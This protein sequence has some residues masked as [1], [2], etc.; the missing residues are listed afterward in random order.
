MPGG[1]A[2][3]AGF[4]WQGRTFAHHDTAFAGDDGETPEPYRDA[5]ANLRD[6]ALRGD[7]GA[8][9]AA[10]CAALAALSRTRVLIPLLAEAGELGVTPEGRTVEK[11]QELSIVTVAA[12][13]GRRVM[14]AF[15]SVGAM[16]EWNPHA[17][18]IPVPAPQMAL[19]AAQELTDLIIVDP[20]HA[21][22]EFGVRRTELQALALGEGGMPP[23]ADDEVRAAFALPLSGDPRVVAVRLRPGDPTARLMAPQLDVEVQLVPGLDR[24]ALAVLLRSAQEEWAASAC[25]A[26][27]VD[28]LRVLPRLV[29]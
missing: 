9:A 18:P 2:D 16:Q 1:D 23:W 13:D 5:V 15:S 25:I 12:P 10:H 6:S 19:A 17:R 3:S 7:L 28:S 24:E 14:P 11:T 27:R 21:D 8:L 4:P 22:T 20:G 29:T 26:D